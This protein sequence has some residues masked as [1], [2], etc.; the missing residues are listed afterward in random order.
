MELPED[1]TTIPETLR[2]QGYATYMVGKWV[3]RKVFA[4]SGTASRASWAVPR[5]FDRFCGFREAFSN[6][7]HPPTLMVDNSE[8]APERYPDGYY[9]TDD[10]PDRAVS[11]IRSSKASD[12]S[13]PVFLYFAH[14]AVHAP[15]HAKPED[16]ERYR[17]SYE[18]GWDAV[19]TARFQKQI[20]L[21][22]IA[23]DTKLPPRN[24]EPGDDVKPWDE[25]TADEKR[26]FARYM[27]GYS[28]MVGTIDESDGRIRQTFEELG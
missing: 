8:V 3:R 14:P 15:L 5:R 20:E 18:R 27:E 9:L 12:S 6:C 24:S 1:V 10:L 11:M 2:A 28:A 19:C 23:A 25:L 13:K 17:G 4:H 26:L 21:G 7:H 16:I 22:V